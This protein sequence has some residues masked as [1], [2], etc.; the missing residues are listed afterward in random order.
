MGKRM[1][2][3]LIIVMSVVLTLLIFVQM[4]IINKAA[5]IKEEQFDQLVKRCL[6]Q[7]STKLEE[8]ETRQFILSEQKRALEQ[9]GFQ[10]AAP[11]RGGIISHKQINFSINMEQDEQ[12]NIKA[13]A[14]VQKHDTIINTPAQSPRAFDALAE[15]NQWERERFYKSFEDRNVFTRNIQYQ[16]ELANRPIEERIKKEVLIES[17]KN[18][19]SSSGIDL[20]YE[21]VV[22][23]YNMGKEKTILQSDDYKDNRKKEHQVLLYT[24]DIGSPKPNYL[25]VYFPHEQKK[26]LKETGIMVVP[27]AILVLLIIGIFT[28]T[29]IIILRQKKLS[30]VKNDFINNMT[31]ELKTPIS[32]ISLA[33][34]MLRDNTVAPAQSTLERITGVIYDE[35]KRLSHQVEKVLQMAVFNEGRL[36]LKFKNIELHEIVSSVVQNFEIRVQSVNGNIIVKKEASNDN[37]YGDQV[38][39]TNVLFNLL[40]NAVKYSKG[41]P[42]IEV[43]TYNK[44]GFIALAIKDNGIGIAREYQ[45]QIFERFYRVPTGNVHDVKGFGLGLHYVSKIVEAHK[46][47]I[48]VESTPNKGTKFKIYFPIKE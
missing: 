26:F 32:T 34:Q 44:K 25:K 24:N 4:N 45:K 20:D 31:H 41:N 5:Q 30:M 11:G 17:L 2:Y 43:S 39:I 6:I 14:S 10:T 38:H 15:L 35:T 9:L 48:K 28:Y 27:T 18:E 22:K 3:I 8:E 19:F 1:I 21:Y 42:E 7:V 23:S 33:S 37:I 29:I 47:T 12:G 46:G 40:D 13:E 16:L 36:K